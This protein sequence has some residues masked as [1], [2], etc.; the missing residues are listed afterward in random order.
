VGVA[1]ASQGR[2]DE[3]RAQFA[4]SLRLDPSHAQA[5]AN[6]GTDAQVG[7]SRGFSFQ[8]QSSLE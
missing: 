6:W 1:L 5:R 7:E 8:T 2:L 4:E 3:A